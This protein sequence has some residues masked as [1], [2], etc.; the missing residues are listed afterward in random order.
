MNK[1][2]CEWLDWRGWMVMTIV[3]AVLLALLAILWPGFRSFIAH[4]ATAGWAAAIATAVASGIALWVSTSTMRAFRIQQRD[5]EELGASIQLFLEPELGLLLGQL[6]WIPGCV[7]RVAVV[8]ELNRDDA[9]AELSTIA[10]S[11]Q[12]PSAKAAIEQLHLLP[13]GKGRVVAH[14]V[15]LLPQWRHSVDRLTRIGPDSQAWGLC[16]RQSDGLTGRLAIMVSDYFG[17]NID[18]DRYVDLHCCVQA[19]REDLAEAAK[20]LRK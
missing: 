8:N 14:I 4:P 19:A 20:L 12:V 1:V 2:I 17:E 5:R 16:R 9:Q 11:I 3:G 15:G 10:E 13:N 6:G 7:E 18:S